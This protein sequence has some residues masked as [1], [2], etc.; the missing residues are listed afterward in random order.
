MWK[1]SLVWKNDSIE[2]TFHV[3]SFE[4][5]KMRFKVIMK[6]GNQI[7]EVELK[8]KLGIIPEK[9]NNPVKVEKE[10]YFEHPVGCH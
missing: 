3:S 5:D 6:N 9:N 4:D 10:E 7:K 2:F 8:M 1:R